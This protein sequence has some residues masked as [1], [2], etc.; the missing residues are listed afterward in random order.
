MLFEG[1]GGASPYRT[2]FIIKQRM[3][4]PRETIPPL[5]SRRVRVPKASRI[6]LQESEGVGAGGLRETLP[7]LAQDTVVVLARAQPL[8]AEP[9][10]RT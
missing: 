9:Q 6:R 3:P 8:A 4:R 2:K 10:A 1:H 5:Q 7:L